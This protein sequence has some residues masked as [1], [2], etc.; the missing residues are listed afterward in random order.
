ME[1]IASPSMVFLHGYVQNSQIFQQRLKNMTKKLNHKFPKLKFLFP[2]APFIV[3]KKQSNINTK[4][5][6]VYRG[7]MTIDNPDGFLSL[8]TIL[9][10][11]LDESINELYSIGE[12][13]PNIQCIFAFSQGS[14]LLLFIILLSLYNDKLNFKQYFPNIKC[15]IFTA[16]FFSPLPENDQFKDVI[17]HITS[18]EHKQCDIPSLHVYGL[19]DE[20]IVAE[21]SREIIQYFTNSEIYE[22]S[23]K[24]FI[25]TGKNDIIFFENYLEKHLKFE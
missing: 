1:N 15:L 23:G 2:D 21:K 4:D 25:P 22:H 7:W 14:E 12:K 8:K 5:N 19:S 20:Y 6:E 16:G 24:H 11:G 10:K 9:Y 18:N 3:E 17:D 13:N